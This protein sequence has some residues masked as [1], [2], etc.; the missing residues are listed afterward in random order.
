MGQRSQSISDDMANA[1]DEEVK[2]IVDGAYQQ[3]KTILTEHNDEL[4]KIAQNLLEY[5]TLTGD[6]I[7]GLIKG[8][9]IKRV[10]VEKKI[11]TKSSLPSSRTQKNDEKSEV[12][13]TQ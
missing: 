2:H 5:E 9:A 8:E 12:G 4:H 1:I 3:A 6:E 7:R 10:E 13:D 11:V